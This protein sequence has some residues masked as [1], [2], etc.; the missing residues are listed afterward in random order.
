MKPQVERSIHPLFLPLPPLSASD[1]RGAGV[2][3]M[4][5]VESGLERPS[6]F[7]AC[8]WKV[9]EVE[10]INPVTRTLVLARPEM[11]ISVDSLCTATGAKY[12]T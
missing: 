4:R 2:V 3:A 1:S 9:Y 7:T 6:I 10:F 5:A 12:T 11:F 8:T